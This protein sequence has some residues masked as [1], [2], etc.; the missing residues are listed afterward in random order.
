MENGGLNKVSLKS[1]KYN[2][3]L[4]ALNIWDQIEREGMPIESTFINVN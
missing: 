2:C 1:V 4:I 3:N